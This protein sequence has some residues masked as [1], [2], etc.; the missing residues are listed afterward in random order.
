VLQSFTHRIFVAFAPFLFSTAVAQPCADHPIGG[1]HILNK[2]PNRPYTATL[3]ATQEQRLSDGNVIR[4]SATLH[5]VRDSTGRTRIEIPAGCFPNQNGDL[6]QI[7]QIS[8]FDP[9]TQ[10][11]QRWFTAGQSWFTTPG[12]G[13]KI[14]TVVRPPDPEPPPKVLTDSSRADPVPPVRESVHTEDLGVRTIAGTLAEGMRATRTVPAGQAGNDVDIVTVE[15]LWVGKNIDT[16]LLENI[17][18]PKDGHI[19]IEVTDLKL[20]EPDPALFVPPSD[21]E[22]EEATVKKVKT[23]TPE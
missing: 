20:G 1:I 8:V 23:T 3:R 12:A 7:L 9:A 18:D 11:Q 5:E 15:E 14:V 22:V 17:D 2:Q 21:Y 13:R 16:V 19:S 6:E 4:A 10:I